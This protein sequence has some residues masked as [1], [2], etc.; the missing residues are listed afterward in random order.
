MKSII[1]LGEEYFYSKHYTHSNDAASTAIFKGYNFYF[2][3]TD[4]VYKKYWLFGDKIVEQRP[5]FAFN[6][7]FDIE[8]P[9][10]DK[11]ELKRILERAVEIY[12]N[13]LI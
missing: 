9:R 12:K 8:D 7:D 3:Y 13:D 4:E 5:K 2:G 1:I 10:M 11:K 6:V